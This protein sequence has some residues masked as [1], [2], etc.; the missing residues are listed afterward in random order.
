MCEFSELSGKH[1]ISDLDSAMCK[2]SGKKCTWCET[3][4]PV[5]K[6]LGK[7]LER[8]KKIQNSKKQL[9]WGVCFL[10]P[11]VVLK[12]T[13]FEPKAQAVVVCGHSYYKTVRTLIL[14]V[15]HEN[16]KTEFSVLVDN[17][18][19]K[20]DEFLAYGSED[21]VIE[22]IKC[23]LKEWFPAKTVEVVA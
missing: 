5:F 20:F 15:Y 19:H 3:T 17:A 8:I 4:E 21:F 23:V 12:K 11:V 16:D 1:E 13:C 2:V 10:E 18:E 7:L 6:D 22:K 14:N 9:G